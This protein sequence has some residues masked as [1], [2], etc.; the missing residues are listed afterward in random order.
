MRLGGASGLLGVA[1]V[2]TRAALPRS[3][4]V[5][6]ARGRLGEFISW[7]RRARDHLGHS[8]TC[9][10][11]TISSTGGM[12]GKRKISDSNGRPRNLNKCWVC[13]PLESPESEGLDWLCCVGLGRPWCDSRLYPPNKQAI[14][15]GDPYGV[16][17]RPCH[18]QGRC[19]CPLPQTWP[20]W[21]HTWHN[22]NCRC[23]CGWSW[24]GLEP[25]RRRR[26]RGL[27]PHQDAKSHAPDRPACVPSHQ[28]RVLTWTP[29]VQVHLLHGKTIAGLH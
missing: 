26:R 19:Y 7:G 2:A 8:T 10:E 4:Q 6:P 29:L 1:Q 22:C 15:G 27:L 20:S 12:Q 18:F 21:E 3:V 5:R 16:A 28:G 25:V 9:L 17:H 24:R 13:P 11:E 23:R 14:Q